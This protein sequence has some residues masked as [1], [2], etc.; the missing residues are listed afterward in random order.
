MASVTSDTT[1]RWVAWA[2]CLNVA[3]EDSPS[4]EAW[5]LLAWI[6][7]RPANED[8][9]WSTIFARVLPQTASGSVLDR[10]CTKL[11]GVESVQP[12]AGGVGAPRGE[13]AIHGMP[14][15]VQVDASVA[16]FAF[17]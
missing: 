4:S 8:V 6:R 1:I 3:R 9:F 5:N 17:G 2:A 10:S 7:R 13:C 16:E 14:Q 15:Q 12:L 11:W